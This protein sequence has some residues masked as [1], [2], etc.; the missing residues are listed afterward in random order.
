M[1]VLNSS[2]KGSFLNCLLAIEK[3]IEVYSKEYNICCVNLSLGG[4]SNDYDTISDF[5]NFFK[6]LYDN[7]ILS[8]IAAG[9]DQLD[10]KDY[11]P[12]SCDYAITVSALKNDENTYIFDHEYSNFGAE[13]DISAPGTSIYSAYIEGNNAVISGTSMAAPHVSAAIALLCLD[14]QYWNGSKAN[15]SA[16]TIEARL[17][18]NVVDLGESGRDK[19]YGWGMVDFRYFNLESKNNDVLSFYDGQNQLNDSDY[20]EFT[21]DFD[22]T[23]R[24][25]DST[26]DIYYTIDGSTPD[27]NS[28]LYT[29][30]IAINISVIFKFIA[31]KVENGTVVSNSPLYT[32]DLFNANDSI[33]DFLSTKMES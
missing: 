2:G 9:N 12:A 1:K 3:I 17:L 5:N 21:E 15:F 7:G 6:T 27:L 29:A 32:V 30:P 31:F 33:D 18:D 14:Q 24:S 20:I 13:I 16:K 8:V 28:N 10:T 23:V 26:Y 25:S 4:A 19:F 22:L 11:V